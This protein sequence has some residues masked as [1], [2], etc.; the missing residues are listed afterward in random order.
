M[1]RITQTLRGSCCTRDGQYTID[2]REVNE[3]VGSEARLDLR[4]GSH[5][6]SRGGAAGRGR[7]CVWAE[8]L[9]CRKTG[10]KGVGGSAPLTLNARQQI[11]EMSTISKRV[12]KWSYATSGCWMLCWRGVVEI[13]TRCRA[14]EAK[15][16][17][18][19][20]SRGRAGLD[21]RDGAET[22]CLS[23]LLV[24]D[25]GQAC[26]VLEWVMGKV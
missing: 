17:D 10:G 4:R 15:L 13:G 19:G 20:R 8:K 21:V 6:A 12:G 3:S 22:R 16:I 26:F 18:G 1:G 5:G 24:D 9:G 11:Q 14:L 23:V 2:C 7:V 25:V